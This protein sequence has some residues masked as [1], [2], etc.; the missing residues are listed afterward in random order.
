L[1]WP[2]GYTD[3]PQSFPESNLVRRE[4]GSAETLL[5]SLDGANGTKAIPPYENSFG[6]A[7]Y[8]RSYPFIYLGWR[9]LRE[10]PGRCYPDAKHHFKPLGPEIIHPFGID[11]FAE[12]W[13]MN[14]RDPVRSEKAQC[15]R[16]RLAGE[17]YG[18]APSSL[19]QSCSQRTVCLDTKS[20]A[21]AGECIED[22]PRFETCELFR[23]TIN[24]WR[25]GKATRVAV[26]R[27]AGCVNG[28]A[29]RSHRPH[30]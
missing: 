27:Y 24:V 16:C 23:S 12:P 21:A 10:W 19:L 6:L 15:L 26:P 1:N 17:N 3:Y 25:F 2:G 28:Y 8:I 14:Q 30:L 20:V 29:L 22:R 11:F 7:R 5:Q 4:N 9:Y 13:R 18:N